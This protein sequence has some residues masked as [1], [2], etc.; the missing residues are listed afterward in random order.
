MCPSPLH[1]NVAAVENDSRKTTY[2]VVTACRAAAA[3]HGMRRH[4]DRDVIHTC[5]GR[6]EI[7][8]TQQVSK[9]SMPA[10]IHY[11]YRHS[12]TITCSQQADCDFILKFIHYKST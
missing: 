10:N 12:F 9:L 6:W 7:A 4:D 3:D 8:A 5:A 2:I 11:S 1:Q